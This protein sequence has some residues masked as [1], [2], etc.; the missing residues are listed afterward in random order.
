MTRKLLQLLL[1]VLFPLTHFGQTPATV[2]LLQNGAFELGADSRSPAPY[3]RPVNWP[4]SVSFTQYSIAGRA[5][6][7]SGF[8]EMNTKRIGGSLAQDVPNQTQR[9]QSYRFSIWVKAGPNTPSV[10][11]TI[12]L[13]GLG[14]VAESG[15]TNFTVGQNWTLVT[16]PLD[17]NKD[18]HV[19]LRA[20]IYMESSGLNFDLDSASLVNTGLQNASFE[21]SSVGWRANNLASSV[22]FGQVVDVSQSRDGGGFLRMSTTM[23]GGS[24]AQDVVSYPSPNQSYAFSVWLKSATETPVP[25]QITLWALGGTQESS[26]T[27]LTVG[28]EWTQVSAPIDV[29]YSGHTALRSEIYLLSTNPID[30]DGALL[31]N[32]GLE[33]ASFEATQLAGTQTTFLAL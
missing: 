22:T 32:T 27:S 23:F 26:F 2:N 3:W 20:E 25:V 10:S 16:C 9:G 24:I 7:G 11:G 29:R 31:V 5:L 4:S 8:L 12:A 1:L 33:N 18:G 15:S 6:D 17:V 30:I 14:G 19:T 28:P 13:W 21:S